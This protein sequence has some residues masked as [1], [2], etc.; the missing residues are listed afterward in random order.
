MVYV[1]EV[2]YV[3]FYPDNDPNDHEIYVTF[4][5]PVTTVVGIPEFKVGIGPPPEL[6]GPYEAF[7]HMGELYVAYQANFGGGGRPAENWYYINIGP[8]LTFENGGNPPVEQSGT[9]IF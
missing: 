2:Y 1:I 6:I 5:S 7:A 9:I 4:T 8:Y 3:E